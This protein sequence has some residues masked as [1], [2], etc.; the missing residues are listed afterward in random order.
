M[1]DSLVLLPMDGA[2]AHCEDAGDGE[3]PKQKRGVA[4]E[5]E[6]KNFGLFG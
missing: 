5:S 2:A 3:E 6:A 4:W 1:R